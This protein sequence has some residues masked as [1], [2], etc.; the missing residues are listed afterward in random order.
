MGLALAKEEE[1]F[2]HRDWALPSSV[3]LFLSTLANFRAKEMG[4]AAMKASPREICTDPHCK[5]VVARNTDGTRVTWSLTRKKP[6][7]TESSI[8]A[9]RPSL[10]I[11][12]SDMPFANIGDQQGLDMGVE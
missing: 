3:S 11:P 1:D 9:N 7:L 8:F 5:G 6:W 10:S 2:W 12:S 4:Q